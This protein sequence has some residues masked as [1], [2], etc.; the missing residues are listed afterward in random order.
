MSH[1]DDDVVELADIFSGK[2][3]AKVAEG[4]Q[5]V[6]DELAE[7]WKSAKDSAAEF[8]HGWKDF[9]LSKNVFDVTI[10]ARGTRKKFYPAIRVVTAASRAR[11]GFIVYL[12]R[13]IP[14]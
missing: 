11:P 12:R 13:N 9:A 5:V 1:K 4:T 10:G 3:A 6:K 2:V 7:E 14:H 8:Y